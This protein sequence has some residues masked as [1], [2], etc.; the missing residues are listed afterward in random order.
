MTQPLYFLD[1][2]LDKLACTHHLYVHL[3]IWKARSS[4]VSLGP[5]VSEEKQSQGT[6]QTPILEDNKEIHCVKLKH[7]VGTISQLRTKQDLFI[8]SWRTRLPF[9]VSMV[10]EPLYNPR[11]TG[12]MLVPIDS[13][14][15]SKSYTTEDTSS[16][17][18]SWA[19]TTFEQH[20]LDHTNGLQTAS[21][22]IG[23]S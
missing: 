14:V 7:P 10:P 5:S 18:H 1:S 6:H 4:R 23:T 13:T 19:A 17:R 16:D 15:A 2:R 8:P 12:C 20:L 11:D 21:L 9:E 22:Q 3:G